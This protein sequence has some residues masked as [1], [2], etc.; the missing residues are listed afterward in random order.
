[1]FREIFKDQTTNAVSAE[2]PSPRSG[3]IDVRLS[4]TAGSAT[5]WLILVDPDSYGEAEVDLEIT[6]TTQAF[7]IRLNPNEKFRFELRDADGTTNI[8]VYFAY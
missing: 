6:D 5:L 1:M 4:G 3:N 8:S 7:P 2:Y